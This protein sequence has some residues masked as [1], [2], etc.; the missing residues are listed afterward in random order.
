VFQLK[1]NVKAIT[2]KGKRRE[3]GG[4]KATGLKSHT[5]WDHDS[6]DA[7]EMDIVCLDGYLQGRLF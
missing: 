2:D 6:R 1:S 5:Q 4:R 3:N 7:E